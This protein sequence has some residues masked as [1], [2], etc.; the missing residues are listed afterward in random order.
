[1]KLYVDK[2]PNEPFLFKVHIK[3]ECIK[4]IEVLYLIAMQTLFAL[5][6]NEL[7]AKT[8]EIDFLMRLARSDQIFKAENACSGS[9]HTV[10]VVE[11]GENENLQIKEEDLDEAELSALTVSEK[12]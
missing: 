10:Y 2:Q 8:P 12:S 5:K 3:A 6:N 9:A 11:S 7:L 4:R 1:M